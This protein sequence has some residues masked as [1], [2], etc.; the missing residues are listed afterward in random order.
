MLKCDDHATGRVVLATLLA[1]GFLSS[2]ACANGIR[3][4]APGLEVELQAGFMNGTLGDGV[5]TF[6]SDD[7]EFMQN[8]LAADGVSTA[9]HISL[10]IA[11]TDDGLAF[12]SLF[13]GL[14]LPGRGGQND[15]TL[16]F[17]SMLDI[18]ANRH[19]N[20]DAGGQVDWFDMGFGTQ[21]VDGIFEWESG[22]TSEGFAWG[23]LEHGIMGTSI[24]MNM[25]LDQL[26]PEGMFQLVTYNGQSWEVESSADFEEGTGQ[27][28]FSFEVIEIPAPAT[29]PLLALAALGRRRRRH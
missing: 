15:S 2:V 20:T 27:F 8:E 9:G 17:N 13:D 3:I 7:L 28:A 25:G 22:T 29:L 1:G 12:V 26:V 16:G 6:S 14:G 21:M 5:E 4:E 10:F 18:S 19:W 11:N 24:Y 23:N